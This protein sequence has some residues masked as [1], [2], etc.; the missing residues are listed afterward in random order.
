MSQ[1]FHSRGKVNLVGT[2]LPPGTS[3][4]LLLEPK[5]HT[6]A[7][8]TLSSGSTAALDLKNKAD[9]ESVFELQPE[10]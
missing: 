4:S 9:I 10:M 5:Y 6:G 1:T 8:D 2:A 3:P 7:G